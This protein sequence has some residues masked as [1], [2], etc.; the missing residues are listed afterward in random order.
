MNN[1][2]AELQV[3][4]LL[5]FCA[6]SSPVTAQPDSR[7]SAFTIEAYDENDYFLPEVPVRIEV[8]AQDGMLNAR[9]DEEYVEVASFG[10]ASFLVSY[11]C[12]QIVTVGGE[13]RFTVAP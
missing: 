3:I 2:L 1:Y 5:A 11:Y 9:S 8:L 10:Q 13:L 4:A 12:Q 6:A 7:F